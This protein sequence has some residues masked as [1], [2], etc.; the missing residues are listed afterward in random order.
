[1]A[2]TIIHSPA[3][4]PV[5]PQQG[6]RGRSTH[7]CDPESIT[8]SHLSEDW[9]K[10]QDN[11]GLTMALGLL[12]SK[13]ILDDRKL[14]TEND[15]LKLVYIF[16]RKKCKCMF[17]NETKY[18]VITALEEMRALSCF[19]RNPGPRGQHGIW[20]M[21]SK[22][23]LLCLTKPHTPTPS[24][25]SSMGCVHP[26]AAEGPSWFTT[27][28]PKQSYSKAWPPSSKH[29]QKAMRD[30]RAESKGK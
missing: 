8:T 29:W 21:L 22:P 23:S 2:V 11:Y 5:L 15:W 28:G 7:G 30:N 9:I 24:S 19:W 26:V 4:D 20:G 13:T 27:T 18:K 17:V 12:C 10:S 1:M 6:W 16:K 3:P 25:S 14:L